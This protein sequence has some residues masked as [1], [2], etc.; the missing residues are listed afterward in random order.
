MTAIAAISHRLPPRARVWAALLGTALGQAWR[1][2][3]AY[4][5]RSVFVTVAVSL[6]I[7]SLSVITATMEGANRRID[8]MVRIFG[9]DA[10]FVRGGNMFS[11]AVGQRTRTIS[12]G[13]VNE[14]RR[15]LPGVYIAA[16]LSL[17]GSVS[18]VNGNRNYQ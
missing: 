16:P 17:R 15:S 1:A 4:R 3:L 7:A 10:A 8:D 9:P 6:G 14:L 5:L 18:L 2:V 12:V 13:D 11:R